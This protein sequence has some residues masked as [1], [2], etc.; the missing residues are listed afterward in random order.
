MSAH[1]RKLPVVDQKPWKD[2]HSI[3]LFVRRAATL[4]RQQHRATP[5]RRR[6]TRDHRVRPRSTRTVPRRVYIRRRTSADRPPTPSRDCRIASRRHCQRSGEHVSES[7]SAYCAAAAWSDVI[8]LLCLRCDVSIRRAL[9]RAAFCWL[10]C[11]SVVVT[12]VWS[13]GE[14]T[15]PHHGSVGQLFVAQGPDF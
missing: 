4:T 14:R 3:P 1:S 10:P 5:P 13:P 2:E 7:P 15:D 8:G 6:A 9:R 11:E 12:Y